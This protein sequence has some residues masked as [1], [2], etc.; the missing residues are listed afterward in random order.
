[1]KFIICSI[2]SFLFCKNVFADNYFISAYKDS[3][4]AHTVEKTADTSSYNNLKRTSITDSF[5][6]QPF[7][8]MKYD[9]S[10]SIGN[11]FKPYKKFTKNTTIESTTNLNIQQQNVSY[12][13]KAIFATQYFLNNASHG[14]FQFDVSV[15]QLNTKVETMGLQLQYN[16]Q[17]SIQHDTTSTFAKPLFDIVGKSMQLTI[18]SNN[19]IQA[20][21]SS[22]TGKS[23]STVLSGLSVAGE[24]FEIG[25]NFGLLLNKNTDSL[26]LSYTWY[27]SLKTPNNSYLTKYTV[28]NILHDEIVL[29]VSGSISQSGTIWSDGHSFKTSFTGTQTGK[30]IIAKN[31]R[32]IKSRNIT[33][34]LQGSVNFEGKEIPAT[35]MSKINE[36]LNPF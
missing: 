21:D 2:I 29:L 27:D 14:L 23:I 24:N 13:T 26:Q 22:E 35:A 32:Q 20:I 4:P 6:Y 15:T 28:Q 19:I 10:Y 16:S 11:I 36:T 17:D 12:K 34:N 7:G 1:M 8:Q 31:T 5:L 3:L 18:D 25:N 9:T 33:Y 30:I